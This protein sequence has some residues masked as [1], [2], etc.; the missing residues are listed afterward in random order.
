MAR[1]MSGN[2]L[3]FAAVGE[4]NGGE[5]PSWPRYDASDPTLVLDDNVE[6][7]A[8]V[9]TSPCDFWDSVLQ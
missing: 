4:P 7:D 8:G 5:G 1:L 9:H 3:R 2:L 6:V